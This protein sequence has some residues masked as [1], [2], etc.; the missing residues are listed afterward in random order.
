MDLLE[1][2]DALDAADRRRIAQVRETALDMVDGVRDIVWYVNPEHD[3]LEALAR[4]MKR[5]SS[6]LLPGREVEMAIELP[7]VPV[8]IDMAFRRNVFL[9]FKELLHNVARHSRA[10]RIRVR[11]RGIGDRLAL[12][13]QDDGVGFDPALASAGDGLASLRRRASQVGGTLEI[14]SA[15]GAGTRVSFEAPLHATV[16]GR[17]L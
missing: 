10:G 16:R 14:Q 3:S 17:E 2:K 13:V 11:V 15:A 6:T 1:R 9:V 5:V 8:A 7:D 4:R 12:Q